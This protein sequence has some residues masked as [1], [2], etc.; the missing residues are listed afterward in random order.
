MPW[1]NANSSTASSASRPDSPPH[2]RCSRPSSLAVC[3]K[4]HR[5]V[6]AGPY[7]LVRHP[8][9]TGLIVIYLGLAMLCATGLAFI[10]VA[11]ITLGLWLKA[12][13]EER[14]VMEELGEV[15]YRAYGTQTHMLV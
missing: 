1:R 5:M 3:N 9:Y 14:F 10:P 15:A 11:I 7:R 4:T 12:R 6:D 2:D 13:L 8:I